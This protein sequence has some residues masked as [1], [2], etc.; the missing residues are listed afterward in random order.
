[1]GD[2]WKSKIEARKNGEGTEKPGHSLIPAYGVN[3]YIVYHKTLINGQCE[4]P[5]CGLCRSLKG[6]GKG[7]VPWLHSKTFPQARERNE[8]SR[9]TFPRLQPHPALTVNPWNHPPAKPLKTS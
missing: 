8:S 2:L 9:N 5:L 7:R 1:M 4:C 6:S 3:P